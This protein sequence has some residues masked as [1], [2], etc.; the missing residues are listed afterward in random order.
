MNTQADASGPAIFDPD[1][2]LIDP[3]MWSES[4]ADRI[5]QTDVQLSLLHTLRHEF[6]K[7]GSV[8][9]LSHICHLSGQSPDC[10]QHLFSNPREAWRLAGLPNPG[11]EAKTYL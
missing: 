2:F 9:A 1:G 6:A 5:A 7:H 3:A 8:T 10:M 11:E 4:L